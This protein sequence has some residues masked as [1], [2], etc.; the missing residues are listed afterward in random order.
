MWVDG[1]KQRVQKRLL[2]DSLREL[3]CSLKNSNPKIEVGFSSFA[4]LRPKNCVLP[5]QSGTHSV[6]VCTIHQNVKMMVDA[7]DL[8]QLTEK[9][10]EKLV[11]YK[12]C[13]AKIN[14]I[15]P[16]EACY[17]NECNECPKI[18]VFQNYLLI[19]EF[20]NL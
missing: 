13:L 2:L 16:T 10:A 15:Q 6:C 7:I 4:K 18:D 19:A 11:D 20:F 17:L 12:D 1:E 8:K 9:K 5:G 14:C 3:Y